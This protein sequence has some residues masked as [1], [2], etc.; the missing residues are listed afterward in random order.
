MALYAIHKR[1]VRFQK[2]IKMYFFIGCQSGCV[3]R[4]ED[5]SMVTATVWKIGS[6]EPTHRPASVSVTKKVGCMFS[7]QVVF[8]ALPLSLPSEESCATNGCRTRVETSV[9]YHLAERRCKWHTVRLTPAGEGE[10][11]RT[12]C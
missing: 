2:L 11:G 9:I 4:L 3:L 1:M 12:A 8:L 7:V 5:T 10:E 6:D